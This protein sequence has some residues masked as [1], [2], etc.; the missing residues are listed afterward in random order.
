MVLACFTDFLHKGKMWI[1]ISEIQFCGLV[2]KLVIVLRVHYPMTFP[3]LEAQDLRT[4][5]RICVFSPNLSHF[6]F[7]ALGFSKTM[8]LFMQDWPN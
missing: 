1:E 6:Y 4:G 7:I 2:K 5:V 8:K 3:L